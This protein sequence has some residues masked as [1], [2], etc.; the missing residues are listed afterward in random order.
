MELQKERTVC[1]VCDCRTSFRFKVYVLIQFR[2]RLRCHVH[3]P[4]SFSYILRCLIFQSISVHIWPPFP[5]LVRH[6]TSLTSS[7]FTFSRGVKIVAGVRG[8]HQ[9]KNRKKAA[10]EVETG[11][12][13]SEER[14]QR[15]VFF[16]SV[17]RPLIQQ[18][19]TKKKKKHIGN[20]SDCRS[21]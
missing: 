17:I 10:C 2:W 8:K 9:H 21:Q 6:L 4:S 3:S 1:W 19:T 14:S 13:W 5:W 16:F 7:V 15:V 11:A 12:P 18:F 20:K